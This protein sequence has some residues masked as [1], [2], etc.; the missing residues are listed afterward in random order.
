M[1]ITSDILYSSEIKN[2]KRKLEIVV[3]AVKIVKRITIFVRQSPKGDVLDASGLGIKGKRMEW[4]ENRKNK[5][6]NYYCCSVTGRTNLKE[7]IRLIQLK[8]NCI[9]WIEFR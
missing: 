3:D 9:H 7:I 5:I 8:I 6:Y 2:G 4:R 1:E